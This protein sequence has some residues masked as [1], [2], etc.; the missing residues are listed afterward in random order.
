MKSRIGFVLFMSAIAA[1][2][3][4]QKAEEP[5]RE[6]PLHHA[7]LVL[8]GDSTTAP[9]GDL[10]IFGTLLQDLLPDVAVV[11][12]GVGGNSTTDAR[13]RFEQDVM[14][15][16]PDVVTVAFGINDAAVDVWKGDTTPRVRIEDYR[17]NL[18]YFVD[19]LEE[20]GSRPILMTPNPLAWTPKLLELYGKP[21]YD[22]GSADGLNV[23]L[24]DY[25]EV[26]RNVAKEDGVALVDVWQI[27]KQHQALHPEE[28]LL[29]DGMHP[30]ERGHRLIAEALLKVLPSVHV[31]F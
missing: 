30:N 16:D 18:R 9:R 19:T 12:A 14:A 23:L 3:P 10:A 26:V 27:F 15:R 28:S 20:R 21:P 1:F 8:F 24:T 17:A 29:L 31:D 13:A 5:S 4:V 2:A 25:A 22:P 6:S 7:T 11:N